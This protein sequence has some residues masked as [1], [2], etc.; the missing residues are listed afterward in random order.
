MAVPVLVQTWLGATHKIDHAFRERGSQ[1]V[2][3]LLDVIH[4]QSILTHLTKAR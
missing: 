3:K 1:K 2:G 4:E